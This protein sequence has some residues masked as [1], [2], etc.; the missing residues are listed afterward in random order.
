V[1][2]IIS[3]RK[4]S[5][6]LNC[7]FVLLVS[8]QIIVRAFPITSLTKEKRISGIHVQS[9][10]DQMVQEGLQLRSCTFQLIKVAFD[11]EVTSEMIEAFRKSLHKAK[12]PLH[13]FQYFALNGHA[14]PETIVKDKEKNATLKY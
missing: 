2:Q 7:F 8:E 9:S 11:E 1:K 5:L 3:K 6:Y 13:P 10:L 14:I 12:N 4:V